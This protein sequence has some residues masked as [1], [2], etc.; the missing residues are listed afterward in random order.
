[1]SECF[2]TQGE[3]A[4]G[5]L[6]TII[7]LFKSAATPTSRPR[8]YDL[9]IGSDH[10]VGDQATKF[11]LQRSTGVG[12]EGSGYVPVNLDPG[13]PAGECD[14]GIAHSTEPTY[15]ASTILLA[16]SMNQ[17]ATIRWYADEGREIMTA[18][19][20]SNG[21]GIYSENSTGVPVHQCTI[22]FRE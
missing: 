16:F 2:A 12:I 3:A 14:S 18:A 17:R 20:Q 22:F 13:G 8:I 1:M 6:K 21:A 11:V 10:A 9:I 5:A 7:N 19:T 4:A 15:T